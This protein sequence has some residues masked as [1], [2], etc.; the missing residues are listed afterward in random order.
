MPQNVASPTI[1]STPGV[2]FA[3][4]D[5]FHMDQR[6]EEDYARAAA[7]ATSIERST[8]ENAAR[9]LTPL[10]HGPSAPCPACRTRPE[11]TKFISDSSALSQAT[12]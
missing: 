10:T 6:L 9:A 12:G 7:I 2:A 8:A 3:S 5:R 11:K 1:R 4:N